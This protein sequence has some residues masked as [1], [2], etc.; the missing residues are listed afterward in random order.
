M[1][2]QRLKEFPMGAKAM[3]VA[4]GLAMLAGCATRPSP[5]VLNPVHLPVH[6]PGHLNAS[7]H[8]DEAAANHVNVLAATNRSPDTAR[9]GFGSAW[10]DNLTY[11]QYAFSVPP[12]RKDTAITYPTSRPDPERQFAVIGRKQLAKAPS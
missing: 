8:S 5:D 2:E 12:N 4:I 9:G 10:A 1:T 7:L 3:L 6:L 11:E